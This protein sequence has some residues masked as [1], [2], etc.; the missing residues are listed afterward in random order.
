MKELLDNAKEFIE[1]G[2]DNLKKKRFNASV[3]DFFKAIAVMC[4]YLIYRDI[5]ILSK[6][7]NDRFNLLQKYFPKIYSEVSVLFKSYTDSYNLRMKIEDAIKL[8]EY[9]YELRDII[10]S[11]K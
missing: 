1:S 11:K 2:E 7:H 4:D 6:N 5:K 10:F 9:A 8:K 3:A